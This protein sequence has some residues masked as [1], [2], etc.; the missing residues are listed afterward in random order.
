M[1]WVLLTKKP[2]HSKHAT[3]C[4]FFVVIGCFFLILVLSYDVVRMGLQYVHRVRVDS[5]AIWIDGSPSCSSKKLDRHGL[6]GAITKTEQ[7][8]DAKLSVGWET[9]T[10]KRTNRSSG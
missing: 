7:Q 1:T 10:M 4:Y 8:L 2:L 9:D 3:P 6:W 5:I